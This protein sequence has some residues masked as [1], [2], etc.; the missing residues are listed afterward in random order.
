MKETA[1][2]EGSHFLLLKGRLNALGYD[3]GFMPV[4]PKLTQAITQTN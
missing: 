1:L 4:I 3:Y 2:E